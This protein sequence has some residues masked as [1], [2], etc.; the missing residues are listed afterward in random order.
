[1]TAVPPEMVRKGRHVPIRAWAGTRITPVLG[2]SVQFSK[3]N[4]KIEKKTVGPIQLI[5]K[6]RKELIIEIRAHKHEPSSCI[7]RCC[8]CRCR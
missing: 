6:I 5:I 4:K 3:S 1:M 8:H 7:L 2:G